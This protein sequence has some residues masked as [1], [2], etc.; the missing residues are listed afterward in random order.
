MVRDCAD[1]SKKGEFNYFSN[2]QREKIKSMA[3][4]RYLLKE[5]A[6][7]EKVRALILTMDTSQPG[8]FSSAREFECELLMDAIGNR[9]ELELTSVALFKRLSSRK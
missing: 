2:S 7:G 1:A 5:S 4:Y 3:A 8:F 9:L 6:N